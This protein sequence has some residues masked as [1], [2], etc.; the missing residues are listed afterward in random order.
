MADYRDDDRLDVGYCPTCWRRLSSLTTEAKG[1]CEVH[2]WVF[3]EFNRPGG[4]DELAS[5]EN[6]EEDE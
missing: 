5:E 2:G 4:Y 3:A 1:F 6:G